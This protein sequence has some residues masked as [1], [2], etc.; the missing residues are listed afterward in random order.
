VPVN[1]PQCAAVRRA[2]QR[3]ARLTH[4]ARSGRCVA[5]AARRA[6]EEEAAMKPR[7][8]IALFALLGVASVA[9]AQDPAPA[10]A[11]KPVTLVRVSAIPDFN[12][13]KLDK[14]A[15]AVCDY[16]TKEVGIE[17]RFEASSDYTATVNGLVANKLDL[18]WYGGLTAVQT[19][20][21]AK[22][23]AVLL[24]CRDVDLEF[25]TYFVANKDAIAKGLV[26]P[27]DKLEDL[28]AML[29]NVSFTFG[30]KMSTSG[31]L[32][33][34]HFLVQAGID[35]EKDFKSPAAYRVSGG[36]AST[37]QA[38]ISGEV[39]LGALNFVY[40]DKA[41]PEE[42]AGAPIVYT[43]PKY[44][45]YCWI[46]HAR[47]GEDVLKKTKQALLQL[48]AK[49]EADKAVLDGW[50]AGK[51]VAADKQQWDG[52]RKVLQALPKDFLK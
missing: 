48:D 4:R 10:T 12:K 29:K 6:E 50:G 39:D 32:M 20:D 15:K 49:K 24:A 3:A 42:K 18:V 16:L 5:N 23:D 26:K 40:Y 27:V 31:H 11:T 46:G 43:T 35:P 41:K 25:K 47:L 22:K 34:R 33:P 45:D 51:F 19:M 9:V 36:H 2:R 38:V 21:A 13:G 52:I 30:D 37:L 1:R 8:A 17:F 28:K 44:V 14:T 7:Q